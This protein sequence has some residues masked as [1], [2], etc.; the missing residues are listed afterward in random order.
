[1][2]AVSVSELKKELKYYSQQELIEVC[3]HLAKYKKDN[4]ELLTYLLFESENEGRYI[5]GIK[6]EIDVGFAEINLGSIY[7][8]KKS[9]R[10]ILRLIKKYIRY[11]KNKETEAEILLYF[12]GKLKALSSLHGYS[13]QMSN[14][15]K[16]QLRLASN[17]I[18]SLHE[19]VQYDLNLEIEKL[20]DSEFK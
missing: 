3:L 19:D 13:Q 8:I 15:F 9:S 14:M 18:D 10:K 11:S 17:A 1:M 4:K 6:E 2:K 20:K 7:Y 5:Q 16:T 12:C